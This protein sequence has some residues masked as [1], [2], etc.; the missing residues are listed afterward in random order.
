MGFLLA[1]FLV[2]FWGGIILLILSITHVVLISPWL[3]LIAWLVIMGIYC[4]CIAI[5]FKKFGDYI[6]YVNMGHYIDE[7]DRAAE[8]KIYK[9]EREKKSAR[10]AFM[11]NEND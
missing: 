2:F 7:V 4:T 8:T 3:V 10:A 11:Y 1:L 9:M 5:L 6:D